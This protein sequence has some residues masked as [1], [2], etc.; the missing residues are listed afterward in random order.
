MENKIVFLGTGGDE[1]VI[2]KQLRRS[3]GILL[4]ADGMQFHINPGPG[5]LNCLAEHNINV[6]ETTAI[7]V[8]DIL[9]KNSNDTM[10]LVES[11]TLN[12]MDTKG[13]LVTNDTAI[14]GTDDYLPI[15]SP[16]HKRFLERVLVVNEDQKLAIGPIEI[17]VLP[18]RSKTPTI[19]FKFLTEF[20]TMAYLSDTAYS[21]KFKELLQEV[22]VMIINI[23]QPFG[24]ESEDSMDCDTA[25][26]IINETKPKIVI[27][28]GFS[29][30]ILKEDPRLIAREFHKKTGI[31]AI[32][33]DD[34]LVLKPQSFLSR[35]KVN[36]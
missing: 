1:A 18:G 4:L 5:A 30:K 3:G 34:G 33:A 25:A 15:I 8:S 2:G 26:K 27:L 24:K 23:S 21:G 32:A 13:V 12:G 17:V 7:F 10:A 14:K 31:Q 6:R 20:F 36:Q 16:K 9:L 19:G 28:T 29:A 22:D 11:M 35:K